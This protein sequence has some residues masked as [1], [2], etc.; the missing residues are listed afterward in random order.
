MKIQINDES[1]NDILKS[2]LVNDYKSLLKSISEL[3]SLEKSESIERY[4][5][6]DLSDQIR[7]KNA[8]EITLEYYHGM[9]WRSLL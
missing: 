2:V 8:L 1:V 5:I 4:E 3:E 9:N 6:K 7:Y